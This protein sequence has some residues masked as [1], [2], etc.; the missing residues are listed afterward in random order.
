M[1]RRPRRHD[2]T[3]V[4]GPSSP[5]M[6]TR[7]TGMPNSSRVRSTATTSPMPAERSAASSAATSASKLSPSSAGMA[8]K[9]RGASPA[10]SACRPGSVRRERSQAEGSSRAPE[11]T[12]SRTWAASVS[13]RSRATSGLGWHPMPSA[14]CPV[15]ARAPSAIRHLKAGIPMSLVMSQIATDMPAR[16]IRSSASPQAGSVT[17]PGSTRRGAVSPGG[18]RPCRVAASR[19]TISQMPWLIASSRW[20]PDASPLEAATKHPVPVGGGSVYAVWT[21]S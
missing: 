2:R 10:R 7:T 17:V 5:G 13:A 1:A 18:R 11:M 21:I 6:M 12:A 9:S 3:V 14:T 19:S 20:L 4:A 15:L 8:V 16:S